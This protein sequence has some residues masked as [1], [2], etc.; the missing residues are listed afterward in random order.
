LSGPELLHAVPDHQDKSAPLQAFRDDG[1][2]FGS[3]RG[4]RMKTVELTP[5][6]RVSRII[7]GGWQMAGGHGPIRPDEAIED[8]IAFADAGIATF[9][10]ADIYTGVEELI[11]SFRMRYRDLRGQSALDA[12]H[13]HTK[14]VPDLDLLP[15]IKKSDVEEIIDRSLSRLRTEQLDLVQ[16]HWWDYRQPGLIETA[17]WLNELRLAGKIRN[18]GGTNLDTERTIAIIDSGVPLTS[19]QVQY[20]LLDN[21][22]MR[23]L[24]PAL[25]G[26]AGH[27]LCYGTVAGGFLSDRWLGKAEPRE[28]LENRSLTK[29]KLIIDDVGGWDFFQALLAA[30]RQV[31]DRH[32]ADIGTVAS[33]LMLRRPEVAGIIVG[34]RNRSHLAENLKIA[35][36]A[37]TDDDLSQT[38]AVLASAKTLP[39]DVYDIERD[40]TGRHGSIMKYNL[41]RG[42]A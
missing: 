35:D 19:M 34:A 10:C 26:R 17:L 41:N 32:D 4:K 28:P 13:V 33:A 23:T 6:Y 22:P 25:R 36:L 9:D 30:L 15:R 7:R 42:A 31:A 20:S 38:G 16:L 40:R 37:L 3:R 5:G 12:V 2:A 11:G 18:V 27:I 1:Y 14:F 29:Y 8:M 24:A 39:G 21:R